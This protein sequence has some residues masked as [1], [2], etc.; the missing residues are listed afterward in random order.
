[1][2]NIFLL[3]IFCL[4]TIISFS[5][6]TV[7]P[8]GLKIGDNAPEF[9]ANDNLG[10]SFNLKNQLEK[11]EVVLIFYR[12]QWCPYCNK[13]LS[14]LNDSLSLII[15]KGALVIAVTPETMDNV[16]KTV[17]K[18]KAS[19]PIISDSALRI[20]K[21]YK[22]NF[23]VDDT[24]QVKYKSYGIDF[25][26]ANGSNGANLPVPATYIIGKDGNIKYAFFNPD[27][28][29]RSSVKSILDNL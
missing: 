4:V 22:V 10:N 23:A 26:L 18:T 6:M 24:T 15:A 13:E 12:G 8:E 25:M 5:Q 17:G 7:Y 14:Q 29:Y 9:T 2:K 3:L 28:R 21:M 1:M 27:F 16:S 11:G 19:F 20:M